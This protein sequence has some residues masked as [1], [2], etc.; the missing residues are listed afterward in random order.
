MLSFYLL[1]FWHN[2]SEADAHEIERRN[3]KGANYSAHK[4]CSN[5]EREREINEKN[6][7]AAKERSSVC[8]FA[9]LLLW[10]VLASTFAFLFARCFGSN[11]F[12]LFSF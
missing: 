9:G 3:I 2:V 1:A 10:Q 11:C 7:N 5:E 6:G 4:I 8:V 12:T